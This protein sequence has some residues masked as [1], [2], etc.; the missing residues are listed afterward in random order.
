ME[1]EVIPR[2]N[3]EKALF[4][5]TAFFI[6]LGTFSL[7]AFLFLVPFVIEPAFTTIFMQF[8]EKP[9][10]CFTTETVHHNSVSNCSWSSCREGCTREVFKCTQI[11]VNYKLSTNAT[12]ATQQT[13][14]YDESTS[15]QQNTNTNNNNNNVRNI[16]DSSSS[17][18]YRQ[19]TIALVSSNRRVER[20]IRSYDDNYENSDASHSIAEENE[21]FMEYSDENT[22]LQR[23]NSEWYFIGARIFPNVKGCGYPPFLNCTIWNKKY[24]KLGTNFSCYR[25]IVDPSL[26]ITYLDLKFNKIK[27]VLAMAI[28]IPSFIISI[29]YLAV[30]YFVIYNEDELDEPLEKDAEEMA[31]DDEMGVGIDGDE[32]TGDEGTGEADID[33]EIDGEDNCIS[34][35]DLDGQLPNGGTSITTGSKP[36][37]P[38]STTDINS[39]GH[40]LKVRMVDEMSRDSLDAGILSNSASVQG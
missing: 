20:A 33:A 27:L 24:Q 21:N 13:V 26:V 19:A 37:T 22:G 16:G 9:A 5:T 39:F 14:D 32:C 25:S 4:Y 12:N 18:S 3:K 40:Q 30:A 6:L 17:S 10:L 36:L 38:N 23:N 2:S 7:F 15:H 28:P 11:R 29:I 31:D 1:L 8:D 34:S 35:T